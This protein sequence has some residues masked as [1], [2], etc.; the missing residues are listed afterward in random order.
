MLL[1]PAGAVAQAPVPRVIL[2]IGDG[3]GVAA[4][5]AARLVAD[6]LAVERLPVVG[7]VDARE[8]GGKI[9]DSGASATAYACG[10]RTF[11]GAIGVGPDSQPVTTIL[12]VAE[13]RGMATGLVATSSVTHATPASF[14]AHVPDRDRQFEIARQIA[15]Q[16]IDVLL[17]GGRRYFDPTVRRDSADLLGD[18]RRR[19]T[20]VDSSGQLQTLDWD[21]VSVLIG[22]FAED[23][24]PRAATRAP[25]LPEMTTA[26]LAV[27]DRAPEGFFLM[28]EGSQPD[29]REHDNEVLEAV[30]A[31]MLDLDR[32]I[33]VALDYRTRHPGT[34]IVV[35]ADHETGGLAVVADSTG[36]YAARYATTGHTGAMVPL[37]AVGPGAERFRGIHEMASV[38][39]M[40]LEVVRGTAA[41][42]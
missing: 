40:L 16:G 11:N 6:S 34:L 22:L 21:T 14:A 17:G 29:W 19:H 35:T 38:G 33:A 3:A 23:G 8:M 37:F 26:A 18:M 5:S 31:E 9:P 30:A 2:F 36:G 27:L 32:A 42:R 13:A 39:Q 25:T 20:L 28:V 4:W 1:Q 12:E 24:M 7:L 10:I 41:T 15:G